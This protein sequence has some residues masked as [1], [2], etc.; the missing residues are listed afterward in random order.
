MKAHWVNMTS[1]NLVECCIWGSDD[2]D[3]E[4]YSLLGCSSASPFQRSVLPSSLGSSESCKKQQKQA[5]DWAVFELHGIVVQK[6]HTLHRLVEVQMF[7]RMCYLHCQ[8]RS[9]SRTQLAAFLA[10]STLKIES[11]YFSRILVNSTSLHG[12]TSKKT[13]CHESLQCFCHRWPWQPCWKNNLNPHASLETVFP[14]A[15]IYTIK[16]RAIKLVLFWWQCQFDLVLGMLFVTSAYKCHVEWN[17]SK[18]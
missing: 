8:V 7:Q 18:R 15:F 12:L 17:L 11:L 13:H 5:M 2:G 3:G 1:C 10:C 14:F 16:N 6:A 4:E 9:A